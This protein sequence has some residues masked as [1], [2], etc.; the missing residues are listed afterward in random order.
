MLEGN[1][2]P[3]A[4]DLIRGPKDQPHELPSELLIGVCTPLATMHTYDGHYRDGI[5]NSNSASTRTTVST[6]LPRVFDTGVDLAMA[7]IASVRVVHRF[8]EPPHQFSSRDQC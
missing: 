8:Q 6:H 2:S 3:S 1:G 4:S 5:V 7:C